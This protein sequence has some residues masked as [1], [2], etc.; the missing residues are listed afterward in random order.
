MIWSFVRTWTLVPAGIMFK[1][2]VAAVVEGV[3]TRDRDM[4]CSAQATRV[5][6]HTVVRDT[7]AIFFISTPPT[8]LGAIWR[9]AAAGGSGLLEFACDAAYGHAGTDAQKLHAGLIHPGLDCR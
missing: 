8:C 4:L 1:R 3:A 6:I 5:R 2:V 7:I 9:P